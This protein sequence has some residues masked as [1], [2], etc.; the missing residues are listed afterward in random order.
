VQLSA[1][2]KYIWNFIAFQ[3]MKS[4]QKQNIR[5]NTLPDT[6]VLEVAPMLFIPFIEN[7]FKYSRIEQ[8]ENAYVFIDL[9]YTNGALHFSI[10]NNIPEK[11]KNKSGSG[12]GIK[13]VKH[14]L[15]IIYKDQFTLDIDSSDIKYKVDLSIYL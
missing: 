7:A 8:I 5:F 10:E 9:E 15:Q 13:N 1:E 11:D 2:I 14:R 6:D 4:E 3:Q 12:L